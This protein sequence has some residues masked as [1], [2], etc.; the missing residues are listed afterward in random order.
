MIEW[1]GWGRPAR[2]LKGRNVRESEGKKKKSFRIERESL[3][4]EYRERRVMGGCSSY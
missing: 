3:S 2:G 1:E 4:V